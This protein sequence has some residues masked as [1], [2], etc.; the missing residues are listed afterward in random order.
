MSQAN[1][2]AENLSNVSDYLSA[3]KTSG[4]SSF[5]LPTSVQNGIDN[6]K[7]KINSSSSTLSTRTQQNSDDIQD[8]LDDVYVECLNPFV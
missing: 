6:I 2:T 1:V 8:G 5:S 4:V 3:A 7:K